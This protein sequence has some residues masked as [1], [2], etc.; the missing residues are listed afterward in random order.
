MDA[1]TS[2]G[3]NANSTVIEADSNM[4]Q[5]VDESVE[6][7]NERLDPTYVTRAQIPT[8][9]EPARTRSY[10]L[11]LLNMHVAFF[12]KEPKTFKQA[13]ECREKEKWL[14][15]MRE[16]HDSLVKNETWKLVDRPKDRNVVNNRWIFKVKQNS[17]GSV[18]R[19]KA[20]LVARGFTQEYGFDYLETFSPVVR[21]TSIRLILAEA[22]QRKMQ[23]KQFDV[24]TAFLNGDLIEEIYM[25]QPTEFTDIS[26][27]VCK[28]Q[29]SLYGLKQASRC[30]NKKFKD[31][32]QLFG[33][34]TCKAD[35]CVFVSRKNGQLTVLAIHVDDGL[36]ISD[37]M[38]CIESVL[39]FL[40]DKFEI[41]SMN[42]DCF[43]GLQIEQRKNGSIFV[44]QSTYANRIL[45]K[46][47]MKECN[48]VA[49]PSDSNK[50][51][52][53][54]ADSEPTKYPYREAVGSLMYLSV[55]TRP[56]IMYAVAIVSRFLEKPTIVHV[57]AVK[58][59]F[60]YLKNTIN[61]G[62]FY[63]SGGESQ[64]IGYSDADHAGDIETRRSTSGYIFKYNDGGIIWSSERQK[65]VSISTM[66][67]EYIAASEAMKELVWIKRLLEEVMKD[68]LKIP[69]YFKRSKHIDIRYHFVREKFEEGAFVLEYV[70][71]ENMIADI[72]TKSLAKERFDC[73]RSLTGVV[74]RA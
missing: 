44:H 26:D 7:D 54:F 27:K 11:S 6:I 52:H 45:E 65:S 61:Y 23:L 70:S 39:N 62:I 68:D 4:S 19:Y 64:L 5:S 37:S 14:T 17:D 74:P 59:I 1:N 24:R 42:V 21:F 73:L 9:V 36:I 8:N 71:S 50:V 48:A 38:E 43:L 67:A 2:V 69:M 60:K 40:C 33:F 49:T 30:W 66:E 53:G 32:I 22:A 15:A 41:K 63:V 16:E 51:L 55:A 28:L 3:Q 46:F 20:R 35:S 47:N 34:I 56:D 57:K 72:F 18:E 10:P 13:I 58:R 25:E 29:R 12:I 31:F